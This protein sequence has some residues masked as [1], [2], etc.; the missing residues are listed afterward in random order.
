MVGGRARALPDGGRVTTQEA[1]P[2]YARIAQ[3]NLE[4]DGMAEKIDIHIGEAL[5]TLPLLTG[6]FDMIF[7]DADKDNIP[8]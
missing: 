5:D 7:I 3:A 8:E 4:S 1:D 6:P 2:E